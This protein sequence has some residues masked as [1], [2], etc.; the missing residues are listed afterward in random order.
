MIEKNKIFKGLN[1]EA[2]EVV[3]VLLLITQSVFL[4]IFYGTFD[5]GAHT[6]FLKTYP[7]EM[8]PKAYI[9]SGIVGILLTSTFSKLQSKIRFSNLSKYTLLFIALFTILIRIFFEFSSAPW[10]VF[11]V[12]ILLGPLNILAILAF[13]GT[14]GRIFNLR[15]GKRLFGIIDSGQ[16]FGI[17]ISSYA[18]PLVLTLLHGTKNLLIISSVSIVFAFIIEMIIARKYNLNIEDQKSTTK[19]EAMEQDQLK[20]KDFLKDRYISYMALFVI[21]SMFAAFFVQY[22]FLVVTNEQYKAEDDLAKFLAFFTGSMMIFTFIIKTFVYSKLVKTYG[23]KIS[24]LLSSVLLAIFTGLAILVGVFSGYGV[25]T[26]GFIYF[27]LFI[28]LSKLFNKTLKDALEGPSFKLLYQSL[29]KNIR[30]DVQAKIDGTINEIAALTSGILLST[31]GLLAFI[32]IIHFSVFLF[33]LLVIWAFITVRL[34]REYRKSLEDSLK[35][36]THTEKEEETTWNLDKK[37]VTPSLLNSQ[38][39]IYKKYNPDEYIPFLLKVVQS[40][41]PTEISNL[42]KQ[43]KIEIYLLKLQNKVA[44]NW[45]SYFSDRI[46]PL[47]MSTLKEVA[48][49]LKSDNET[50]YF[51]ALTYLFEL[52]KKN[53]LS[54]LWALLRVPDTQVQT[55]TIRFCGTVQEFETCN[56]L[57]EF[58]ESE[59]LF[60]DAFLSLK[61]MSDK[62]YSLLI[63][64]FY[65]TEVTLSTQIAILDLIG[66]QNK[67]EVINFL[68][69]NI[70][71]HKK[72]IRK[73][74]IESLINLNFK[75]SEKDYPKLFHAL[76]ANSQQVAWDI[77]AMAS[78]KD[79]EKSEVLFKSLEFEYQEHINQLIHV[80]AI[81]YDSQSVQHVKNHL[82]SGNSEGIGYALELFD[83][84]LSDEIK[85]M[86]LAAFEDLPLTEKAHL[87]ENYFPVEISSPEKMILRIINRDPNLI[88]LTTKKI[89]L[90]LYTQ[91]Y[92]EITNDIIAQLFNPEPE[93]HLIANQIVNKIDP[94]KLT[95]IKNRIQTKNRLKLAKQSM[96]EGLDSISN[97]P[98]STSEI[99][100]KYF[101]IEP[102]EYIELLSNFEFY[103]YNPSNIL[104]TK[105]QVTN[106]FVFLIID[107]DPNSINSV[108]YKLHFEGKYGVNEVLLE[109]DLLLVGI[110]KE[111]MNKLAV[112][113]KKFTQKLINNLQND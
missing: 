87:L 92:E 42:N 22:S 91:Y 9:L 89:A 35:E 90:Q 109:K 24:L 64:I 72:E 11:L 76:T 97:Y 99:I 65:K 111:Q 3:P 105:E 21:F 52:D 95:Q 101:N 103:S 34:Y 61:Q 30:F 81:T 66:N 70:S 49:L 8:I 10:T 104:T 43:H 94:E 50:D 62:C 51:S 7:E 45:N 37:E 13:W 40:I 106:Y 86:I 26:T 80:L 28:S 27:F 39:E 31:L 69:D 41:Q 67:P 74:T 79:A 59:S 32:K 18:I 33:V 68:L 2:A 57:V 84:F 55:I 53:Q 56:T 77:S 85:P 17:I 48:H 15:Q 20:L 12:F 6:L 112:S 110:K 100:Q 63:Q 36:K 44:D 73:K 23:L 82:Y 60:A 88:S 1:I 5:I 102:P 14:T 19:G 96:T 29:K 98:I 113:N 107:Q 47:K 108:G 93:L 58:T 71:N 4:G 78:L 38:L 46:E 25:G 83:L 75:A 16:V 54:A